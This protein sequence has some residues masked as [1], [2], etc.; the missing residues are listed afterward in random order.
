MLQQ[1]RL[2]QLLSLR[3]AAEADFGDA[4]LRTHF[5]Q[6]TGQGE[7]AHGAGDGIK[8]AEQKEAEVIAEMEVALGVGKGAVKGRLLLDEDVIEH[9]AK[10]RQQL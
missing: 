5:W 8:K 9:L 7:A 10:A 1:G 3:K 4:E 6:R 2:D